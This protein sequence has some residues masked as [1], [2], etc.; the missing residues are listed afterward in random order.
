MKLSLRLKLVLAVIL[1]AVLGFLAVSVIGSRLSV[2]R[3]TKRM[4]DRLY[5]A[6]NYLSASYRVNTGSV[7]QGEIEAMAYALKADIWIMDTEGMVLTHSGN[8]AVPEESIPFRPAAG[9]GSY[10]MTGTFYD[11]YQEDVLSVYA[12]LVTNIAT[13]GYV[14][15]HYPVSLIEQ[16]ADQA[17]GI[18]YIIYAVML[19]LLIIGAL[20]ADFMFI[21]RVKKLK[22]AATE[23]ANGNL[24]FPLKLAGKDELQDTSL[25]LQDLARQ[26]GSSSEDQ[27]RFLANI[28]HDFRSPLTSIRGYMMAIQDGTIPPEM[29][30]KYIDVVITEADRLTKLANSLI[31]MTQVENGIILEKTTF[32]INDMIRDILPT[33]EGPVTEKHLVFDVTF[34]EEHALVFADKDRISQ[35]IYNLTD[36]AIKFSNNN[37]SIDISTTLRG[38]R[39]FISVRDHGIGIEK[40][41]LNKIWERF[42]K[43]DASRGKDKK[44]SGLGLSIVREIIQ[45]HK[46]NI[47]VISTPGVG[48][49]FIF[50]LPAAY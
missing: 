30:G 9:D 11:I 35:V 14:I 46:E 20:A 8:G 33:F 16:G 10:Y 15:L 39:V 40:E 47:D 43:S 48:T 29:Q 32:D 12:P 4:L 28:S 42:Y 36:N 45:A 34:E 22:E 24:S 44:G 18:A 7:N 38:D 3:E 13:R 2:R 31:D 23:Y 19:G 6:A 17:L 49:E 25:A 41:E 26:L 1:A 50:T 5:Q 37:S 21:H 27:H